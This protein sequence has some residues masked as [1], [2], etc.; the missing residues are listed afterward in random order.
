M[1][2]TVAVADVVWLDLN[3]IGLPEEARTHDPDKLESLA[4][5]LK[6]DGQLQEIVVTPRNAGNAQRNAEGTENA[7]PIAQVAMPRYEVVA[8]V[9]RVLAARKLGWEKIRALVKEGLSEFDKARI[10][11]AENEEREDADPF[12]QASQL[13]KMMKAKSWSQNQLAESLGT[14]KG[15]VNNY[16]GLLSLDPQVAE[17]VKRLTAPIGQ[18]IQ[19]MR[20]TDP[21]EQLKLAQECHDK[22][23]SVRQL[24]GLVDKKLGSTEPKAKKTQEPLPD[25]VWKG[26]KIA[27]NRPFSP[28]EETKDAYIAWLSQ[29]L[30]AVLEEKSCKP[31]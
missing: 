26:E 1:E 31:T 24:K 21:K 9:G 10:T 12:Y 19:L 13:D 23:L 15:S 25:V 28:K 30:D 16:L 20:L 6:V 7:L 22:D 29:A 27:I 3:L 14:A 5:D 18:L 8:G 11:Y 2:N 4:A 17:A